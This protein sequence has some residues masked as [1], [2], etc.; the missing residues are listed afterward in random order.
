MAR[1]PGNLGSRGGGAVLEKSK[2]SMKQEVR[3]VEPKLDQDGGGGNNG[4]NIFNGGGG[5][6]ECPLHIKITYKIF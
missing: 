6:G 1:G 2:L 5:E 3:T 4:K